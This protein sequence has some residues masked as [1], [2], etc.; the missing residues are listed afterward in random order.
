[1]KNN[2]IGN[3]YTGFSN[4]GSPKS[5]LILTISSNKPSHFRGSLW[6]QKSPYIH[7]RNHRIKVSDSFSDLQWLL[8]HDSKGWLPEFQTPCPAS[9]LSWIARG[10]WFWYPPG[11]TEQATQRRISK[12]RLVSQVQ[13]GIQGPYRHPIDKNCEFIFCQSYRWL[14]IGHERFEA[15]VSLLAKWTGLV[16]LSWLNFLG[17][18]KLQV[19]TSLRNQLS[20]FSRDPWH[21]L[22]LDS[23]AMPQV[24]LA[25]RPSP[26]CFS[27]AL[28]QFLI[29]ASRIHIIHDMLWII[30]GK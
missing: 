9:W 1:M 7:G 8:R 30:K 13:K 21:S 2:P 14:A 3:V 25:G 18:E 24:T 17:S 10:D 11:I 20:R 23:V 6:L 22:G 19:P 12:W 26:S 27:T 29:I 4:R 16:T 15:S 28:D 5:S